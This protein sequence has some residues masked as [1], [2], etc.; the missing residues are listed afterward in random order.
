MRGMAARL[1]A[2]AQRAKAPVCILWITLEE[3]SM[4]YGGKR[5]IGGLALLAFGI[6]S[7]PASAQQFTARDEQPTISAPPADGPSVTA[8]PG[9]TF[10][11]PPQPVPSLKL[12][13]GLAAE[14]GKGNLPGQD[15]ADGSGGIQSQHLSP[16]ETDSLF[17]SKDFEQ[18]MQLYDRP[19]HGAKAS[20]T[21]QFGHFGEAALGN[22]A[23]MGVT[24]AI[25]GHLPD[26][27]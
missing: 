20:A 19:A 22:L 17:A 14:A 10:D 23:I 12:P 6:W 5:Y 16:A 3:V 4:R 25:E 1:R 2:A 11:P 7:L 24:A 8:R 15:L 26:G 27:H 18:S 21:Q 13:I 9:D